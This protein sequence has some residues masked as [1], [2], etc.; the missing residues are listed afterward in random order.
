MSQE[1]AEAVG[2]SGRITAVL[3][4]SQLDTAA[5]WLLGVSLIV[6][7]AAAARSEVGKAK[8]M[9]AWRGKVPFDIRFPIGAVAGGFAVFF[10]SDLYVIL[11][12]G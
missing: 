8:I 11:W 4:L 3:L 2:P 7:V 10:S 6:L 12:R 1:M 9:D 5:A